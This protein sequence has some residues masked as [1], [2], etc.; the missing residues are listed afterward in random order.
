MDSLDYMETAAA[1]VTELL[2]LA[3][4]PASNDTTFVC[5]NHELTVYDCLEKPVAT[6][7][8]L[9]F[10]RQKRSPKMCTTSNCLVSCW[11]FCLCLKDGWPSVFFGCRSQ[12]EVVIFI[13]CN[14]VAV[15]FLPIPGR[16]TPSFL[17][18]PNCVHFCVVKAAPRLGQLA[19][20]ETFA[21]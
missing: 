21:A 6:S 10:S 14:V 17:T 7:F 9:C 4:P 20:C 19:K 15:S 18:P 11:A 3:L 16:F 8:F 5:Q 1:F 13:D 2:S 12:H